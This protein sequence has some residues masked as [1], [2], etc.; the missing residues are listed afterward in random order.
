M[1][2]IVTVP[3]YAPFIREIAKHPI[4]SGIRLNTVMPI[5]EPIP[6]L[7]RRL[8]EEAR[9]KDVWVDLKGRQLRIATHGVPPYTEIRL[10]HRIEVQTPV[11]AYFSGGREVA[12]VVGVDGDR[13][14]M[15]DGPRRVVGPGEAVNI[16]D[17]SLR[18]DGYL[19]GTDRA[20]LEAAAAVGNP[21]VMLSFVEGEQDIAQARAIHPDA[22]IAAKIESRRG[23]AYARESWDP[24]GAQ[25]L[26]AARGDLYLEVKR[27]HEIIGALEDLVR[28]D[29]HAIVASRLFSS[30][31]Q[32]YMPEA[33]DIGDADSL[34]RMGYTTF[35]LGDEVCLQR[36]S[37][38]SALN[39]LDAMATEYG[40]R[41]A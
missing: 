23:L 9:G 12:T 4:V 41:H 34:M 28:E 21:H 25:R 13:L 5:K 1:D 29:P 10:T 2:A 15:Q 26:M 39:L 37:V 11:R 19:T 27:P 20:Y 8:K 14:I 38:L 30:L 33:A 6:D 24:A 35:M 18:I 36:D 22:I 40:R 17:E 32:G 31:A 16:P 7:L 3:P